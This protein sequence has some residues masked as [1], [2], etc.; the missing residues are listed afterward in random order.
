L[1]LQSLWAVLNSKLATFYHFNASPK[2]TKGSFPKILVEDIKNFP[3]PQM[4]ANQQSVLKVKVNSILKA[5]G[6]D[7]V[8]LEREIDDMVY[9]LYGLT[10]DEVKTIEPEYSTSREEYEDTA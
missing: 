1:T 7:T 2:A 6:A 3:I 9:R 10:Y 5:E 8:K 4:S